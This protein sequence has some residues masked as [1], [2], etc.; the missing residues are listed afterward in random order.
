MSYYA[1]VS[2]G[3]VIDVIVA[4]ISFFD[5]FIDSS[6]GDWVETKIDGSIRANYASVGYTYDIVNDVFIPPR[7]FNS[8]VLNEN[9]Y[10]WEN[11]VPYPTSEGTWVWD[12]ETLQYIRTDE[13]VDYSLGPQE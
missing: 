13:G 12:E 10:Q 3:T 7:E 11:P 8:W 9:I 6:P 5:T 1:K 4:H 2:N